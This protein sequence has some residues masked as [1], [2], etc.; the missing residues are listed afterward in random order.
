[1]I[2]DDG[3]H[4]YRVVAVDPIPSIT[5]KPKEPRQNEAR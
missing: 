5:T 3:Q 2:E 1:L 4:P